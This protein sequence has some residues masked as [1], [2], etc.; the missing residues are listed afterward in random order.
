[1]ELKNVLKFHQ[2]PYGMTQCVMLTSTKII[3]L[4]SYFSFDLIHR[5]WICQ[6]NKGVS[7]PTT[8]ITVP[9]TFPGYF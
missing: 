6:I 4:C 2:I 8:N 5:G 1:M 7:P 3:M 9:D